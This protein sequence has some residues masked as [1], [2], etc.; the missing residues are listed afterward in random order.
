MLHLI[1]GK[2]PYQIRSALAATIAK[3]SATQAQSL[4]VIRLDCR[5]ENTLDALHRQLKYPSFLHQ[6]RIIV[7]SNAAHASMGEILE[8]YDIP[9][10]SDIILLATINTS[11]KDADKK[12]LAKLQKIAPSS[13]HAE[14]LSGKELEVWARAYCS[15]R[16]SDLPPSAWAHLLRRVGEDMLQLSHELEKLTAYA[17]ATPIDVDMITLL[18][19]ARHDHDT[20]ELSNAVAAHD[21][22]ATLKALWRSLRDGTPEQVVL[23]S[24]ASG[25][26]NLIMIQD[27]ASRKAS[28]A[29][30]ATTIGLHPFVVSKSLAGARLATPQKLQKAFLS[31]TELERS[32]KDG[33]AHLTDGLFHVVLSL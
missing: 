22:R 5:D 6:P 15:D 20:W 13:T 1:H 12:I 14:A 19:S 25:L 30:I 23:G 32:S 21:K 28:S 4:E 24:L 33:T 11:E 16:G 10:L 2:D 9:N 27:V 31:L 18:T 29:V 17:G 7:A 8:E 26:R 3:Q